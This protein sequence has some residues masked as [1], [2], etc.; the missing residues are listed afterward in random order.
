LKPYESAPG[1]A[2]LGKKAIRA[3]NAD[4]LLTAFDRFATGPTKF[5]VQE[6]IPGDDDQLSGISASGIAIVPSTA[7]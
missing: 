1:R 5:M 2:V 3:D 7:G 6:F 4:E